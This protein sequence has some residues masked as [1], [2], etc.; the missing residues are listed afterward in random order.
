[1][2]KR[3]LLIAAFLGALT[4]AG[5]GGGDDGNQLLAASSNATV[6]VNASNGP[7][8]TS[9]VAN[10]AFAFDAGVP[11]FGTTGPT[12]VTFT[13]T[14][15]TTLPDNA[16]S[17]QQTFRIQEGTN[18][19]TGPMEFGSCR[20]VINSSTFAATHPLGNGKIVVI[21]SCVVTALVAGIPADNAP[22]TTSLTLTLN[23]RVSKVITVTATIRTDGTIVINNITIAIVPTRPFT[24][25]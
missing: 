4:L 23:A 2:K 22:H 18:A 24:G 8:V 25:A 21:S 7:S 3:I 9:S 12:T 16:A 1:M 5:C 17:V 13:T 20:F 19:A 11:E 15:P 10:Q 14:P 6:A